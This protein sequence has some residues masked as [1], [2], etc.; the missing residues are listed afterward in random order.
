LENKPNIDLKLIESNQDSSLIIG[1][2]EKLINQEDLNKKSDKLTMTNNSK[3]LQRSKSYNS[4]PP[5]SKRR[6][7]KLYATGVSDWD[8]TDSEAGSNE[9]NGNFDEPESYQTHF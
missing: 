9:T 7:F 6:T 4:R 1:P 8:S 5:S 2:S 3:N